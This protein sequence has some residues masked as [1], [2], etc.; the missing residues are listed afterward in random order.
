MSKNYNQTPENCKYCGGRLDIESLYQGRQY[1]K[2]DIERG[3]PDCSYKHNQFLGKMRKIKTSNDPNHIKYR[4]RI[5][6]RL[7]NQLTTE[8]LLHPLLTMVLSKKTESDE[9]EQF[10]KELIAQ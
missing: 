3:Y 10:Y 8:F 4:E 6:K 7:D 1:H 5:Q 9:V 2:R